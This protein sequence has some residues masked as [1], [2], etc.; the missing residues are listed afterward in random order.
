MEALLAFLILAGC[1]V[2]VEQ[3][4]R[5]RIV[6]LERLVRDMGT[7]QL[8]MYESQTDISKLLVDITTEL[9]RV[10]G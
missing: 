5:Q 4:L 2:A 10:N 6:V 9:E 7:L 1:F 8:S 3:Q